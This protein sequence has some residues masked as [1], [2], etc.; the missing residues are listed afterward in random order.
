MECEIGIHTTGRWSLLA[1]SIS[2]LFNYVLG[3]CVVFCALLDV[4]GSRRITFMD[5]LLPPSL[6]T[7]H[8]SLPPCRTT[9]GD[10]IIEANF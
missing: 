4:S 5:P 7:T 3:G 1:T 2:Q 10:H 8:T 9:P 6:F